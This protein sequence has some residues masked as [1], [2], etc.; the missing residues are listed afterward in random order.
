MTEGNHEN[1]PNQ[2][3][4]NQGLNLELCKYESIVMNFDW[5]CALRIQNFITDHTSLSAELE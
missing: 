4:Q 1:N 5:C 2:F 3:G